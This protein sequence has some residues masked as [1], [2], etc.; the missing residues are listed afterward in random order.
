[1][2]SI[3]NIA[4][5]Q[6][7]SMQN[8]TA[9]TGASAAKPTSGGHGAHGAHGAKTASD[10]DSFLAT[11]NQ[12]LQQAGST[13]GSS[14]QAAGTAS[15][16]ITGLQSSFQSLMQDLAVNGTAGQSAT[17]AGTASLSNTLQA[18]LANLKNVGNASATGM[19]VHASA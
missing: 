1:M 10:L 13:A 2:T 14:T 3:G 18:Q 6:A 17:Q 9:P 11:L 5:Q 12:V 15:Q 19:L 8:T 16:G 4:A 7:L